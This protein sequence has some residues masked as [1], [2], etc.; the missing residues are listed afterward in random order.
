[1]WGSKS[2]SHNTKK[3]IK[4]INEIDFALANAG[5]KGKYCLQC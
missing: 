4:M 1:M 2:P 5:T 3:L